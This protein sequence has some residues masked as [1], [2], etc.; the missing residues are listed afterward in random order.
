MQK[1]NNIICIWQ[2]IILEI[3][4]AFNAKIR[5]CFFNVRIAKMTTLPHGK[6]EQNPSVVVTILIVNVDNAA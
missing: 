3:V 2:V 5:D 6:F 1:S 4:K